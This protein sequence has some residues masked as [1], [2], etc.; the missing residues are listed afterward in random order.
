MS[1]AL[2]FANGL[3]EEE[4]PGIS[5]ADAVCKFLVRCLFFGSSFLLEAIQRSGQ[6][7]GSLFLGSVFDLKHFRGFVH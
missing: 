1:Q 6:T 4:F 2:A 7:L 3:L 5:R